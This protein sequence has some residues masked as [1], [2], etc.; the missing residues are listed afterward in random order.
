M[1]VDTMNILIQPN[2]L[3]ELFEAY[4][5][6]D[7]KKIGVYLLEALNRSQIRP[8]KL[9]IPA[10][11]TLL[12]SRKA[13]RIKWIR[14]CLTHEPFL[15]YLYEQMTDLD[16]AV[17]QEMVYDADGALERNRFEAKYGKLP[18]TSYSAFSYHYGQKKSKPFPPLALFVLNSRWMP[19]ELQAHFQG[20]VPKPRDLVTPTINQ[21]PSRVPVAFS[22]DDM[23]PL[24]QHLTEQPA[25]NDL[26]AILRL[27]DRG[28]VSVSSKTGKPTKACIKS[29]RNVLFGGDFYEADT[30][31]H[32]RWDIQ[33]GASGIRPFAWIMLL[34]AGGLAKSG[35]A[36]LVLS[37]TGHLALN[38]PPQEVI[39]QLWRRWLNNT[40]LHEMSRI[41][42]IKGQKSRRRPLYVAPP[43]R[44]N[45]SEALAELDEGVWIKTTDFFKFLTAND[46]DFDVVRDAWGLYIGDQHYGSFGYSHI[47]WDHLNGRFARV[48]LL[49][50]AATLGLI[51]VALV[52]P[53]GALDDISELWGA[54]EFSC[55]SRYDGLWA[56]RLTSLGAWI[57]GKRQEYTPQFYDDASLRVLPN[58]EIALMSS[59]A[60]SADEL[61]LERFCTQASERVWRIDSKKLLAAVEEGIDVESVVTFLSDRNPGDLPQPVRAF[62][63]DVREKTGKV[64]DCGEAILIKCADKALARLIACDSRSQKLCLP[65]GD[66]FLAVPKNKEK[67]FRKALRKLGYIVNRQQAKR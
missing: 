65:A 56:L 6:E 25:L 26:T 4:I 33:M 15:R 24:V 60:A 54:D 61:F 48:L 35:G 31:A 67:A 39:A 1:E 37:R 7:L 16:Q 47:T 59:V 10:K 17:V 43:C 19:R 36:K 3:S 51:D 46:H 50:Y 14:I 66:T 42:V 53:W 2:S 40:L 44:Q 30:E 28:K 58:L 8:P 52:L 5:L 49:E 34:Q 57:V 23:A 45:I 27:I 32:H 63:D 22:N 18:E 20:F 55:L 11:A 29:I 9:E 21:L 12:P 41:E 62:F 38:K 13:E 64:Q